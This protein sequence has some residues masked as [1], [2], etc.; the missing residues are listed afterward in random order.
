M[1]TLSLLI[2]ILSF[3]I[4]IAQDL[5]LHGKPVAKSVIWVSGKG[6]DPA[7]K[8]TWSI[9]PSK[10]GDWQQLPGITTKEIVL[11]TTYAGKYLKCEVAKSSDNE[12]VKKISRV[13]TESPIVSNGN[14]NTD[15]FKN[16]GLGL[17]VHYLKDIYNKEGGSEAWNK[18][19]DRFNTEQFAIDCKRAG[20]SYVMWALGQNDGYYCSP[21]ATYDSICGVKPG[22]LCSTRD[23]PMD[24]YKSLSKRNIRLILYLPGNPPHSN[25]Q[26]VKGFDYTYGKDTPTS[27]YTQARLEAVIREWS[28]RYGK[29]VSGWWFDG[30]YRSGI[31]QTRSDMNLAHNISTHTLAAKA[32]NYNSIVTYNYGVD[33]IQS[34]SPYD[35]YSAGEE[36]NIGQLPDGRWISEGI[37]WF[38]FTFL[39]KSW[40]SGGVRYKTSDLTAWAQKVFEK[41][42]IM[43]FDAKTNATGAID[44]DQLAQLAAISKVQMV[45]KRQ[46]RAARKK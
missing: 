23:L 36:N 37:Q 43:C 44:S 35:D 4:A 7:A 26:A 17:M 28:L 6:V 3:K 14:Q 21:N 20:V 31:I 30:M 33:K 38:H 10:N 1:K 27:Q 19:V 29:K 15:W 16:A 5:I 18:A 32:G 9:S 24:I 42:G 40:G 13:I 22:E 39:G 46:K 41:E 25:K 12:Q 45:V 34:D 8:F 2:F 11:L